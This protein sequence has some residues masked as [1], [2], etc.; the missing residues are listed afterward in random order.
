MATR[1]AV[2]VLAEGSLALKH[3]VHYAPHRHSTPHCL[4]FSPDSNYLAVGMGEGTV[5]ILDVYGRHAAAAWVSEV[6][7]K[8][9]RLTSG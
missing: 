8:Q 6:L 7:G 1:A 4:A 9:V 2:L 3:T 5:D